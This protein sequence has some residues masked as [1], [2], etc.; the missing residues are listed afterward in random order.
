MDVSKNFRYWQF[1]T[2]VKPSK[3][4]LCQLFC[5]LNRVANHWNEGKLRVSEAQNRCDCRSV[6]VISPL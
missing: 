4:T 5:G 3:Q 6:V 1:K 2:D